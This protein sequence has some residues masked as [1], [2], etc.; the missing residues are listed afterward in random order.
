MEATSSSSLARALAS[1]SEDADAVAKKLITEF[2]SANAVFGAD[3]A[4]LTRSAP[5]AVVEH[6]YAMKAWMREALHSAVTRGPVM[7]THEDV[8]NYLQFDLSPLRV[9]Q[10]RV[11]YIDKYLKLITD[12][13]AGVGDE[14][15]VSA[16]V[17]EV[18]R[19]VLHLGA[20]SIIL[21]HNHPGGG[22]TPTTNDIEYTRQFVDAG[23][24]LNFEVL[25]HIIVA[26]ENVISMKHLRLF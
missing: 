7:R 8:M 11:L 15:G 14:G 5:P 10:F 9:E 13:I 18:C 25:D 12:D 4:T 6:L 16:S 20:S 2:G 1:V 23:R 21:A 24:A 3:V 22:T 17:K 26:K 19:R